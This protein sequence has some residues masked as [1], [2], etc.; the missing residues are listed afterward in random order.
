VNL[1]CDDEEILRQRE[2]QV[3]VIKN[4]TTA[5]TSSQFTLIMTTTGQTQKFWRATTSGSIQMFPTT[6]CQ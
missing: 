4:P 6:G 3:V 1:S 2:M 5:V